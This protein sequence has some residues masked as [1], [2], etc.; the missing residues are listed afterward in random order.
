MRAEIN[1]A[2]AYHQPSSRN[3]HLLQLQFHP[4]P[5]NQYCQRWDSSLSLYWCSV[6]LVAHVMTCSNLKSSFPFCSKR[7]RPRKW[8]DRYFMVLSHNQHKI[9]KNINKFWLVKSELAQGWFFV[10]VHDVIINKVSL[11]W[12]QVFSR[13]LHKPP[14]DNSKWNSLSWVPSHPLC[15]DP[16]SNADIIVL[17]IL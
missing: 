10:Q 9:W 2:T 11:H 16:P 13:H 3:A 12:F 15:I 6:N 5:P 4:S 1:N 14:T 7:L 8:G 17:F